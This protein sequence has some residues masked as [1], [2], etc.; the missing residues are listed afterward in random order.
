MLLQIQGFG[1]V[2]FN[3][4]LN[5]LGNVI[6]YLVCIVTFIWCVNVNLI[7]AQVLIHTK[8]VNVYTTRVQYYLA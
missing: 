7:K 8:Y 4:L 2:R 3:V 1:E 6:A 5:L